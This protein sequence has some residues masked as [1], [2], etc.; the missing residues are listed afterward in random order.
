[1]FLFLEST[2]SEAESRRIILCRNII[3]IQGS[4]TRISQKDNVLDNVDVE[5]RRILQRNIV[6]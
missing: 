4:R 5:R 6:L 3:D 2:T 1:M